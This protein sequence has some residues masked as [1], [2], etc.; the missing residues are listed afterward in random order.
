MY[1]S[2]EPYVVVKELQ[3]AEILDTDILCIA[4]DGVFDVL[5]NQEVIDTLRQEIFY[6]RVKDVKDANDENEDDNNVND[7]DDDEKDEYEEEA[8]LEIDISKIDRACG[9]LGLKSYAKGTMD[10]VTIFAVPLKQI[11]E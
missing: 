5:T 8:N 3:S 2:A 1:L 7:N 11:F 6:R 10:D 4:C 9:V